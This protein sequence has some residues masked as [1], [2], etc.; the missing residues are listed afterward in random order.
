MRIKDHQ[1]QS[2]ECQAKL[3]WYIYWAYEHLDAPYIFIVYMIFVSTVLI[4]L[5]VLRE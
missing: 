1:S 2:R 4:V 3:F 5:K